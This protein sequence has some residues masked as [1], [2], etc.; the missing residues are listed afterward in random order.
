MAP[1]ACISDMLSAN[2][3]ILIDSIKPYLVLKSILMTDLLLDSMYDFGIFT[4][5]HART[6]AHTH[7]RTHLSD[8]ALV[9]YQ[10]C[11]YTYPI[12]GYSWMTNSP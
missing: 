6:Y 12:K 1:P 5:A 11:S 9:Y 7:L 4:H 10:H 3:L 2:V 8:V